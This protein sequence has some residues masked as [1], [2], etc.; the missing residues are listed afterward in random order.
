MCCPANPPKWMP[1]YE[2]PDAPPPDLDHPGPE[3]AMGE[4]K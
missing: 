3:G 4:L 1:V 2:G